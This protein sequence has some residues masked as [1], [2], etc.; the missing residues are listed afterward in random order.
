M[1]ALGAS[2]LW[3]TLAAQADPYSFTADRLTLSAPT[4]D[5]PG[6]VADLQ[7][8]TLA[9]PEGQLKADALRACAPGQ[10][11]GEGLEITRCRCA[12]PPWRLR[13][14]AAEVELT[15]GAWLRWPVLWV[16]AVPVAAAPA[17]YLPL[18][19]RES[20][21]L[22]PRL[23]WDAEE[24]L[25]GDLPIFLT[26]GDHADLTLR[27]GWRGDLGP[28]LGA[29][30]RWATTPT[31]GGSL[32]GLALSDG[33]FSVDGD[34]AAQAGP[35]ALHLQGGIAD[36]RALYDTLHPGYLQRRR[37]H[38]LGAAG[39]TLQAGGITLGV[40]GTHLSDLRR[41]E[42]D[43]L[44]QQGVYQ[45]Q[46]EIW[47]HWAL[48]EGPMQIAL[49]GRFGRLRRPA[50]PEDGPDQLDRV[51]L[52]IEGRAPLWLGPLQIVPRFGALAAHVG[53]GD[54]ASAQRSAGHGGL[55][56]ALGARRRFAWGRHEIRLIAHG[57][58]ADETRGGPE[59]LLA[60]PVEPALRSLSSQRAGLMLRQRL[61]VGGWRA[62]ADVGRAYEGADPVG[63]WD[64]VMAR[65]RLRGS[66]LGLSAAGSGPEALTLG[67]RL[68]PEAGPHVEGGYTRFTAGADH[69]WLRQISGA[70]D[71][72]IEAPIL[73]TTDARA[74]GTALITARL[75]LDRWSLGYTVAL[76]ALDDRPGAI[77]AIGQQGRLTHQGR[78]GCWSAGLQI[79]H[80]RQRPAPDVW[81]SLSL[82]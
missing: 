17:W 29:G 50:G 66:W 32:D 49:S 27:P 11:S 61:D 41:P 13:A 22:L 76:G 44:Q 16:G 31:A 2:L 56:V 25:Y 21:L 54:G 34:G 38:R 73:Y 28:A 14:E 80:E 24:G 81:L 5:C 37:D 70:E 59:A 1:I 52:H 39:V 9:G 43:L 77:T 26:L 79:N 53:A 10:L 69:P 45:P 3:L 58:L 62:L 63:G 72:G 55:S 47:S 18:T 40:R 36:D 23:G 42:G 75:P 46:P 65:L 12:D 19:A 82:H 7:A 74:P 67:A 6:G 8:V 71:L 30:L 64:P 15:E 78:C 20:G 51:D 48:G 33:H 68:G 60:D 57:R 4:A 35:L